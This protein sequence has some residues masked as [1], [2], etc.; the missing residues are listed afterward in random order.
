[1]LPGE[2]SL[3]KRESRMPSNL[4]QRIITGVLALPPVLLAAAFGGWAFT[5]LISLFVVVGALEFYALGRGRLIQGSALIGVPT[6]M[7]V[8]LAFHLQTDVLW[9]VILAL[10]LLGAAASIVLE[11]LRHRNPRRSILQ[12]ITMLTG[13][14]YIGFPA[15]FAVAMRALQPDGLLWVVLAEVGALGTDTFAYIGGHLWGRLRLAPNV[16]PSKTIEGAVTGGTV[17]FLLMIIILITLNRLTPSLFLLA[18]ATPF[19]ATLGDLLE[20]AIKRFFQ[21]KD[22]HLVGLDILPGH[23]GI[24]D[25]VDSSLL[26]ITVFYCYLLAMGIAA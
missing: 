24:L 1:M 6:C 2:Q 18:A 19:I 14:I 11:L 10:T 7:V 5:L 17:G 12:T 20:S 13:V 4:T 21:V 25:R 9:T 22:S 16:S 8:M 23:G 3:E 15:G 26:V